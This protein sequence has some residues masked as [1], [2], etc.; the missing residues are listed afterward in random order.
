M[1]LDLAPTNPH[2]LSAVYD[3]HFAV[4]SA[5]TPELLDAAHALRYQVYCV[6]HGFEDPAKQLGERE[7]DSYDAQS[8]HAVLIS[9]PSGDVVGC[10][11][12]ILPCRGAE[13]GSLPIR[14]LLSA[15]D[16]R[17]LDMFPRHRTAEISRYAIDK[18]YRRRQ[19]EGLY[20]DVAWNDPSTVALR[21]LVPQ[22][23]LGLMRGVCLLAAEHDIETVCAA[24]SAP[25]LRLLERFG[26]VFERLGPPIDYHGQRQPCVANG[27]QLLAGMAQRNQD[28]YHLVAQTP[29]GMSAPSLRSH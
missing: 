10:V 1:S 16:G 26:L 14:E 7:W 24:M 27:E 19:G 29:R 13:F 2:D 21:R 18:R 12:L 11:R 6:E 22:M 20:P 25:L 28:Y 17:R 23:S 3:S 8:V 9:K 5:D 15:A 4:V